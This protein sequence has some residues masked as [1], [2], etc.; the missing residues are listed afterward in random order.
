M[1]NGKATQVIGFMLTDQFSM[2]AFTAA[3]EP[4]R[5]ANRVTGRDL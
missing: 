5:L 2:I 3:L 1:G 4:L